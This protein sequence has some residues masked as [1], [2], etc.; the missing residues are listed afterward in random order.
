MT[1]DPI[2]LLIALALLGL[3]LGAGIVAGCDTVRLNR[4]ARAAAE[5]RP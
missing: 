3:A 4:T 1:R 2:G 5:A